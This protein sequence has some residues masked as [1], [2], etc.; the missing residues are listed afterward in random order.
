MNTVVN[1]TADVIAVLPRIDMDF[2]DVFL[3][4]GDSGWHTERRLPRMSTR[5]SITSSIIP[6]KFTD[7]SY[8]FLPVWSSWFPGSVPG[9]GLFF[10]E[11][12][13]SLS[14]NSSLEPSG[15]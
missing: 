15:G 6:F 9:I 14:V 2:G 4:A 7:S 12:H 13:V 3:P 5:E 10:T 1:I 8:T 11:T